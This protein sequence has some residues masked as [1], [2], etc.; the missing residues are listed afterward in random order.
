MSTTKG[1]KPLQ[2]KKVK[3]GKPKF[4]FELSPSRQPKRHKELW[5]L[6]DELNKVFTVSDIT[7]YTSLVDSYYSAYTCIYSS[8]YLWLDYSSYLY[9]VYELRSINCYLNVRNTDYL[10]LVYQEQSRLLFDDLYN[11]YI[12][13]LNINKK[14]IVSS[15]LRSTC[16]WFVYHI[17][18]ASYNNSLGIKLSYDKNFYTKYKGD[19]SGRVVQKL[20][21]MLS[22]QG[23]VYM[24]KGYYLKDN[25]S[26][27]STGKV[28]TSGTTKT[29]MTL[30]LIRGEGLTKYYH[31]RPMNNKQ[32]RNHT[33]QI[34]CE[35][36]V[37]VRVK[38]KCK[39]SINK[40][41][42]PVE[43]IDKLE[44]SE[45]IMKNL[46]DK[47]QSSVVSVGGYEIPELTFRRIWIGDIYS[48][49][50]I[51]DNGSFQGKSKQMRKGILIDGAPSVT[52]D[53]SSIHP[54]ILYTIEGISLPDDFD[55]YPELSFKL[56]QKRVSRFKKFYGIEKYNPKRSLAKITLLILLNANSVYEAKEAILNKIK[57][58][59]TKGL[60]CQECYMDFIGVPDNIDIDQVIKEVM[61]HNKPI[62]KYFA[63]GVSTMLMNKDSEIIV[64][65][66][67]KLT[68]IDCVCLPLH[69]SIT[70]REDFLD[71]AV[72]ALQFGYKEVLGSLVN[73]KYEIE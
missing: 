46:Y 6:E 1:A 69:D 42:Y 13:V 64:N 36:L 34:S 41:D 58:D 68:Q 25:V 33:P 40:E 20:V 5:D 54:R 52:I 67:N 51:Y 28:T 4:R 30:L 7:G 35:S 72:L 18:R 14:N 12:D 62:M 27:S 11:Y 32:A 66:I 50:R 22:N 38:S 43:W 44:E 59:N 26:K 56:E 61:E 24:F 37:E 16:N 45:N 63:T 8:D 47:I 57:K 10:G 70:V 55:P 9:S 15:K 73:F 21:D 17:N 49:G 29:A 60:T 39:E 31:K 23:S 53:L 48:H 65:A 2:K 3:R 19:V 71:D